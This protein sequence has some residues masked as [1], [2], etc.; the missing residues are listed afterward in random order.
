M[1][2]IALILIA[3]MCAC[4]GDYEEKCV[5]GKT[6]YRQDPHHAW[7][8]V[9]GTPSHAAITPVPCVVEPSSGGPK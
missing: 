5:D 4:E 1:K 6:Y 7:K 2:I 9:D 3:F 8:L